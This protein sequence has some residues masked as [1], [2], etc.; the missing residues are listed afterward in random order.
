MKDDMSIIRSEE[1]LRQVRL[2]PGC[3]YNF[4]GEADATL[5]LT[6]YFEKF[7]L[8]LTILKK[9]RSFQKRRRSRPAGA[10]RPGGYRGGK[11]EP[12]SE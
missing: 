5:S 1:A 10:G 9:N 12:P 3:W 8:G 2:Y 6:G 11:E 4:R 7:R